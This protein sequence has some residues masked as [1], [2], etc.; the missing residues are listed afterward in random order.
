MTEEKSLRDISDIL[1]KN[2]TKYRNKNPF[3]FQHPYRAVS[4]GSS[5][6]GKTFS[7]LKHIILNKD[8]PFDK[9]IWVAPAFSNEQ[10]KLQEVKKKLGSK[11]IMIDGLD[12]EKIQK[13]IDEKPKDQQWLIVFDDLINSIDNKMIKDLFISGR[14]KNISTIEILQ[15]VFAGK[16]ARTHRLNC[17][18]Y[19]LHNFNSP[20]EIKRLIRQ[21]EP[22]DV[23]DVMEY[24][25]QSTHKDKGKGCLIIDKKYHAKGDGSQ[26]LKYRDNALDQ[27]WV[28]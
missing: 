6:A 1:T 2:E 14:H 27:V 24:Y 5:G 21:L 3:E 11:M 25:K 12:T 26:H 19:I 4:V 22:D 15:Q 23:N 17:D 10:S 28:K 7:I 13:L 9:V 18:Y 8:T 16:D 20:D